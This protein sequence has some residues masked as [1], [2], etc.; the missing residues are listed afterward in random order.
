MNSQW[1]T[2]YDPNEEQFWEKKGK[3]IAWKTL[4]ITTIALT[5]SFITWFLF[6]VVVIKLPK[7][8]FDFSD[9]Q[10]FWLAAMPGLA[11]GL[12]RILNTFLIPLF[13]TRKVVTVTTLIK[14]IPL[15]MLGFA[16][17]NPETSYSY[18]MLIAFLMGIG[19]GDFSS[20]MPS[21]SLF[22]PKKELGTA[23]GIQAGI[24]NFGV[25]LVQLLSPLVLSLGIFS[26]VG[27][28]EIIAASGEVIFLENVA[29]IYII[30]LFLIGIWAW[31]SLKNIPV[32]ASFKEQLDIFGD[33]HT[34]YCTLTYF[35]TFGT[36]AGLAAAFPMMIKSLYVPLE[37]DLDPLKYAFYGP[38]IGS[39]VRVIFG[40]IADKTG[41]AILTHITGIALII[42]FA[43]LI[44][45]GYLTPTAIEQFPVFVTIILLI[46]F[47]TGVGNAATFKQFPIIFSDSPRR[48]AGVIGWTSAIAAF[49]PFV[50]NVL[51]TQSR[52]FTGDTRLFFGLVFVICLWATF[53][54]WKFYTRKGCER[55]S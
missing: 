21:T 41:G 37:A 36:F 30:P 8:G 47:F 32:T 9:D 52:A 5:I 25:C 14:I 11:G 4:I 46:F 23:L 48:A 45:G 22:F 1:L 26:F 53:I 18:F 39:L 55:P 35:M 3:K 20:Y 7:I 31:V 51:I 12:L 15:L 42:L 27:G 44:L 40:K 17:M 38:L 6:S 13:G 16:V 33:K 19:G 10:L 43:I 29:F 54:N 28:G 49:G 2:N 50:F 34:W 24:G